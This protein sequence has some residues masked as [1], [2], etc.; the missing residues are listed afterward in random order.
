MPHL[1]ARPPCIKSESKTLYF[2]EVASRPPDMKQRRPQHNVPHACLPDGCLGTVAYRMASATGQT[3]SLAGHA[4]GRRWGEGCL[5]ASHQ[6][7]VHSQ[8]VPLRT[9]VCP[10]DFST[11]AV[12]HRLPSCHA[13]RKQHAYRCNHRDYQPSGR[14][15]FFFF[16]M[17]RYTLSPISQNAIFLR[18]S[19]PAPPRRSCSPCCGIVSARPCQPAPPADIPHSKSWRPPQCAAPALPSGRQSRY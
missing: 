1:S 18:P 4:N 3:A 17:Q 14:H 12:L 8:V 6:K 16:R 15:R 19:A 10:A 13:R 11:C 5:S 7:V 9:V 2:V